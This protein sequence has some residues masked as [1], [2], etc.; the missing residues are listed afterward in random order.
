MTHIESVDILEKQN[1]EKQKRN[2]RE[3]CSHKKEKYQSIWIYLV[4][5]LG[6]RHVLKY[7]DK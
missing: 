3:T 6:Q 4:T 2:L 7:V 1:S 5:I